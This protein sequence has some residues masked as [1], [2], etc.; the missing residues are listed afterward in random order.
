MWT[1]ELVT[2]RSRAHVES[3]LEGEVVAEAIHPVLGAEVITA[4]ASN[5]QGHDVSDVRVVLAPPAD[6]QPLHRLSAAV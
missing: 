1:H 5:I 4:V 2:Q 3:V 6:V